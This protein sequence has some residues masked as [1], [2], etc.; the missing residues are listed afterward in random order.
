MADAGRARLQTFERVQL[1]HRRGGR[2]PSRWA[3]TSSPAVCCSWRSARCRSPWAWWRAGLSLQAPDPGRPVLLVRA[4]HPERART[5]VEQLQATRFRQQRR[6]RYPWPLSIDPMG[7]PPSAVVLR[8][9]APLSP[10]VPGT[11]PV[12]V[13]P[14]LTLCQP[15]AND[16]PVHQGGPWRTGRGAGAADFRIPGARRAPRTPR[17]SS[18]KRPGRGADPGRG[19]TRARAP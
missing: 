17:E 6:P 7:Y 3:G 9:V 15:P 14:P 19:S 16:G 11:R 5:G 4:E 12:R 1:A 13:G 18:R 8:G 10:A 2:V